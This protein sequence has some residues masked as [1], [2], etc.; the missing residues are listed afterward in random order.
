MEDEETNKHHDDPYSIETTAWIAFYVWILSSIIIPT[1]D[2][3]FSYHHDNL[4]W[5]SFFTRVCKNHCAERPHVATPKNVLYVS[6][7][8]IDFAEILS[9][10]PLSVELWSY[11]GCS[12]TVSLFAFEKKEKLLIK[13]LFAV[14]CT[15]L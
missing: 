6:S 12:A 11:A 5:N 10:G 15:S 3:A 2:F 9:L 7:N 13:A 14:Y 4:F 1:V 8:F